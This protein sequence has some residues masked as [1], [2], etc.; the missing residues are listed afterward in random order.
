MTSST[1]LSA[2]E[3]A[4]MQELLPGL[5]AGTLAAEL[6]ARVQQHVNECEA[7]RAELAWQQR[8]QQAEPPLP[9]GL[10]M[11]AALAR[12]L[13]KLDAA[14]QEAAVL[15]QQAPTV[16]LQA[17]AAATPSPHQPGRASDIHSVSQWWQRWRSW[18][19]QH[20][21]QR[22]AL[23]AQFAAIVLLV[24]HQAGPQ[25]GALPAYQMLGHGAASMPDVLVVFKADAREQ[26]IQQLLRQYGAQIVGGPTVTGAYMLEVDSAQQA[27]LLAAL[28]AA[29]AVESA[30]ALTAQTS[31]GKQP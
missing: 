2:H 24:L 18:L 14:G 19:A 16:Q 29:P 1:I 17:P 21:W 26:D 10:D 11:E 6:A 9:A 22:W 27:P 7:C 13:P 5:L 28:Q 20:Q 23:G 8:L 15:Q 3:H 31:M 30:A 25:Q 4:A 12:L